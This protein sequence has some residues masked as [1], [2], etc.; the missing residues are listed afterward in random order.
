[1]RRIKKLV[2]TI[3]LGV[4]VGCELVTALDYEKIECPEGRTQCDGLCWDLSLS[5][6]HCGAC[7]NACNLYEQKTCVDGACGCAPGFTQCGQ[8][9]VSTAAD[10]QNCGA[11]GNKC[12]VNELCSSGV[13]AEYGCAYPYVEC[14]ASCVDLTNNSLHCGACHKSCF[15]S[16]CYNSVCYDLDAG[17]DSSDAPADVDG[18]SNDADSNAADASPSEDA[19]SGTDADGD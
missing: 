4:A 6:Q 14:G 5:T 16:P 2:G 19:E 3:A 10:P 11:C 18:D 7:G 8:A 15:G 17:E 12:K 9:C 13:C 1:M